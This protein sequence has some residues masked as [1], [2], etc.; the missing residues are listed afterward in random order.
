MEVAGRWRYLYGP[1]AGDHALTSAVGPSNHA[2][3]LL[4][5]TGSQ[6]LDADCDQPGAKSR[7]TRDFRHFGR[8]KSRAFVEARALKLPKVRKAWPVTNEDHAE[9]QA[10]GGGVVTRRDFLAGLGYTT[11]GVAIGM[12]I[13][14]GVSEIG[15]NDAAPSVAAPVTPPPSADTANGETT[16]TPPTV[17]PA[18]IRGHPRV[19]VASLSELEVGQPIAFN[20]P[21][22]VAPASLFKLGRAAAGGIGPDDDIVAFATDCTH[23][24]CPL[25]D[26]FREDHSVLG[27]M[28]D[29]ST[30]W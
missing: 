30:S 27:P 15:E 2:D 16:S 22:E 14:V 4:G 29:S 19:R 3:R 20:Y 28:G 9:Q 17:M 25:A 18:V 21:T 5:C 8:D 6:L 23:L 7:V 12:A 13:G 10:P 24:G 26:F 11:A 1:L